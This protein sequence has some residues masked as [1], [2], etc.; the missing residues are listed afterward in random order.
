[1][2]PRLPPSPTG[3]RCR[4]LGPTQ[5]R[6]AGA[7]ALCLKGDV[8]DRPSVERAVEQAAEQ[9][10]GPHILVANAGGCCWM[11]GSRWVGWVPPP[12]EAAQ[13]GNWVGLQKLPAWVTRSCGSTPPYHVT[14]QASAM[15]AGILGKLQHAD[16]VSRHV[17]H[18]VLETNVTGV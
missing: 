9:L 10:G 17:W 16:K 12:A 18:D 5:V 8:R 2:S 3:C 4:P 6:D 1:M 15:T 7:Q 14:P 11:G 13:P